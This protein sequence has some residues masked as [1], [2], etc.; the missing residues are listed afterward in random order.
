METIQLFANDFLLFAERIFGIFANN[1]NEEFDL[2][3]FEKEVS[4]E[5]RNL[6]RVITKRSLEALDEYFVEN[7][8]ER[9]HWNVLR[10]PE[11]KTILTTLGE[12]VYNRR[13]YKNAVTGQTCHLVDH[14]CGIRAHEHVAPALKAML[15][16]RAAE[17]PYS[18]AAEGTEVSKQTVHHII[19]KLEIENDES[20]KEQAQKK[21][22]KVLYVEA[23]EA[24]VSLQ[25]GKSLIMPLIYVHEGWMQENSRR[26]L[27]NP[28]YISELKDS[29]ELWYKILDYIDNHY[30]FEKIERIFIGGDGASWI[31]KGLEIIP[32]S[33]YILDRF[34]LMKYLKRGSLGDK[35]ALKT[36]TG[37]TEECDYDGLIEVL[38]AIK[39]AG[40][41]EAQKAR[42]QEC[43]TYVTNN[44]D[45]IENYKKN[46]DKVKGV[47]AEGHVSSIL[48]DR[49]TSRPKG[50]C[51]V[52]VKTIAV[53][54]ALR[55]NGVNL[56]EKIS[57]T[58]KAKKEEAAP[59]VSIK[60]TAKPKN[61]RGAK[62][63]YEK[64]FQAGIP[65][66]SGSVNNLSQALRGLTAQKA[67]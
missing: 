43:I 2:C 22:L 45:G 17:M 9:K 51:E 53:L 63:K 44:W 33:E 25:N 48:A 27:I 39:E 66:L 50:W 40:V 52:C 57:S 54:R 5:L 14:I 10:G 60:R 58:L 13:Y 34:H 46:A 21:E 49:L 11:S 64:Y 47:S 1:C 61:Q 29:E 30:E 41:T 37:L 55:A 7:P 38:S 26:C 3:R 42:V 16:A 18:K 23:D 8:Q 62:A 59:E 4:S 36:L 35:G 24:H 31:K 65:A 12:V 28:Y 67:I 56:F 19:K 15:A 6:G 32:K 20:E